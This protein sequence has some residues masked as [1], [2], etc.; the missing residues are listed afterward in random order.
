MDTTDP[1]RLQQAESDEI[2]TGFFQLDSKLDNKLAD[3][4]LHVLRSSWHIAHQHEY[5]KSYV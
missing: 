3:D 4:I 1:L 5:I 2:S